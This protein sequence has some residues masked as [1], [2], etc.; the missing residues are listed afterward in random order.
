MAHLA[1]L[2][3]TRGN[4]L[5]ILL[6]GATL[7]GW[8][9]SLGEARCCAKHGDILAGRVKED[10][11]RMPRKRA[12]T[13][14][15]LPLCPAAIISHVVR[16]VLRG[17]RFPVSHLSYCRRST[18]GWSVSDLNRKGPSG[19]ESSCVTVARWTH[20]FSP[21]LV[22]IQL[23][24][25]SYL[26]HSIVK[27]LHPFLPRRCPFPLTAAD[28]RTVVSSNLFFSHLPS[29]RSLANSQIEMFNGAFQALGEH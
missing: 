26:A 10:A 13:K 1:V 12:N 7:N 6:S 4:I 21:N 3:P 8:A 14:S 27:V 17:S 11:D 16:R 25:E 2:P 18:I 19:R 22:Q 15:P 23:L 29:C 5:S 9:C 28:A 20:L 24:N